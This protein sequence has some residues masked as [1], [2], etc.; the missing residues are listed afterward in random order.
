MRCFIKG[1]ADLAPPQNFIHTG[2]QMHVA[3]IRIRENPFQLFVRLTCNSMTILSG[4]ERRPSIG[5]LRETALRAEE[6]RGAPTRTIR[7]S[8]GGNEDPRT[9]K[10]G[11]GHRAEEI[12]QRK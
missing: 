8:C 2:E 4:P 1:L 10:K 6:V 5:S 9:L 7:P 11:H 12:V 3:P